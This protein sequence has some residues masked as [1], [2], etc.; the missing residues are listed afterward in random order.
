MWKF[1]AKVIKKE[2]YEGIM[3]KFFRDA[4][5]SPNQRERIQYTLQHAYLIPGPAGK[6]MP[7]VRSSLKTRR[8]GKKPVR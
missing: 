2:E 3:R 8:F 5:L 1:F 7:G 4:D 6:E